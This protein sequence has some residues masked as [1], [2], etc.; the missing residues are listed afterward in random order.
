MLGG[1]QLR[2]NRA[3]AF[4]RGGKGLSVS[5]NNLTGTWF[6]HAEGCGGGKLDLI[7]RVNGGTRSDAM[8]WLAAE[9]GVPLDVESGTDDV[10]ACAQRAAVKRDL[11]S[12]RL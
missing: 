10:D 1:G 12:A 6:D 5:L 9:L 11:P 7:A 8:K 2:R 4:Y 3:Q